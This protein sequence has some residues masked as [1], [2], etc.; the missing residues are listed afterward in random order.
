VFDEREYAEKM[1]REGFLS[2]NVKFELRIL[3]KYFFFEQNKP[4]KEI[5]DILN[6]FCEVWVPGFR[7]EIYY[8]LINAVL[9]YVER[10]NC[11][12]ITIDGVFISQEFVDYINN[13]NMSRDMKKILF[14]LGVWGEINAKLC[15]SKD[16]AYSYYNYR[17]LK[18]VA[19]VQSNGSIFDP[20]HELYN[21]G[22]IRACYTGAIELLFLKNIEQ[23]E[24]LYKITDFK[25]IGNWLDFY[26][27][28]KNYYSCQKCKAIFKKGNAKANSQVYCSECSKPKPIGSKLISCVACGKEFFINAKATNKTRC[29]NCYSEHRQK[30]LSNRAK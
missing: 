9:S 2:T 13:L 10:N 19:N 18:E 1:M 15:Y 6:S 24:P 25:N 4:T 11:K 14:T 3:A 17:D 12:Y 28:V 21:L 7:K 27:G 23:G 8:R 20:M 26:N 30:Y 16:F 22:Y 5:K 29:N